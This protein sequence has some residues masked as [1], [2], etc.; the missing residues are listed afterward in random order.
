[1][2][3]FAKITTEF[4]LVDILGHFHAIR[5]EV[6][7]YARGLNRLDYIFC[8]QPLLSAVS[9]CG[10]EPFNHHIFSDHRALFVDWNKLLLFGAQA[11]TV[12]AQSHRH[13]QSKSM[14]SRSKY[15]NSLYEYCTSHN[16]FARIQALEK[17]P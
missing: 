5:N 10:A 8:S 17:D 2:S 15:I 1:M 6:S 13:L 9:S 14:P 4:E 7:T 3:G 16:I 11:L 12:V